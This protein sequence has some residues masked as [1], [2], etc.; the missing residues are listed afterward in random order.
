MRLRRVRLVL[1]A[2]AVTL[3]AAAAALA[4]GA[5]DSEPASAP[6]LQTA[7]PEARQPEAQASPDPLP[8]SDQEPA[9][10]SEE[11]QAG[12]A[13]MTQ[14]KFFSDVR[15]TYVRDRE[16][17]EG[18]SQ[19]SLNEVDTLI[20]SEL[21]DKVQVLS[22]VI[23]HFVAETNETALDIERLQVRYTLSKYLSLR[24][25]RLYIPVSY[26]NYNFHHV[27]WFQTAAN[28]PDMHR[29]EDDGGLLPTHGVGIDAVGRLE[30][31]AA[32]FDYTVLVSNGRHSDP[33]QT[34]VI[35]DQNRSK[36]L[37][38]Y[39]MVS[40][41][42]TPGLSLGGSVYLDKLPTHLPGGDIRE[43]ILSGYLTYVHDKLE[44]LGEYNG[45]RHEEPGTRQV[46]NTKG[47]YAQFAVHLGRWRPYYRYD[48]QDPDPHDPYF[49]VREDVK[50]HSVGVRWD[51]LN[52]NALFGEYSHRK[53]DQGLGTHEFTLRTAFTF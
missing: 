28:R 44:F 19:F 40:P 47:Y 2:P 15:A 4:S 32:D 49:G 6:T 31:K 45:I 41:N 46:F 17:R 18:K 35:V 5:A 26:W 22:E 14:L 52:W 43:R 50:R 8:P 34:Q 42:A 51:V 3:A 12:H 37:S 11:P 20:T 13:P 33:F 16:T 1:L 48:R 10:A 9:P 27:I 23:Y 21:T 39:L 53:A 29:F 24:A 38:L 7:A 30:T 25:G 36:A